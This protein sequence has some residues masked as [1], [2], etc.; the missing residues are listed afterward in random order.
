MKK[1]RCT[2]KINGN[3]TKKR[4]YSKNKKG[5]LRFFTLK[6]ITTAL[7]L[8]LLRL[9]KIVIGRQHGLF[10]LVGN[11]SE[12]VKIEEVKDEIKDEPEDESTTESNAP[13]YTES[14]APVCTQSKAPVRTQSKAPVWVDEDDE[15]I[16]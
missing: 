9:E 16:E 4:N 1:H 6:L 2:I 11:S 13:V 8:H 5:W 7:I 3:L 15:K 14:K 12:D 10:D